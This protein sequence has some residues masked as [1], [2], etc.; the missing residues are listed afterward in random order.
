MMR[1]RCCEEGRTV[2]REGG[3]GC[4]VE[5]CVEE[6]AVGRERR[7]WEITRG[8]QSSPILHFDRCFSVL[9]HKEVIS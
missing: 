4:C 2:E 6:V 3:E 5:V 9:V 1:L 8:Y 7:K